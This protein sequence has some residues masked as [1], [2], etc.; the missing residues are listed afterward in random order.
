MPIVRA[1]QTAEYI[2]Y[3][4]TNSAEILEAAQTHSWV[5]AAIISEADEVLTLLL[6][7]DWP[8]L[9]SVL[10]AGSYLAFLGPEVI[11]AAAW[12]ERFIV[13]E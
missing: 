9:L 8:D 3:D 6:Y 7:P 13:K 10:S 11:S 2:M 12:A 1:I 5:D 4:G